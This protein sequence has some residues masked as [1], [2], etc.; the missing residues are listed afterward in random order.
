MHSQQ[1]P[2]NRQITPCTLPQ[3]YCPFY[4]VS[5]QPLH[6]PLLQMQPP[7]CCSARFQ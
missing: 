3:I 1:R 4:H 5:K 7:G 6:P 2:L